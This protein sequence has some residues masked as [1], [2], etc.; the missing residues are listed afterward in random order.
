MKSHFLPLHIVFKDSDK[1]SLVEALLKNLSEKH[2]FDHVHL[3]HKEGTVG[4]CL[5]YS[6]DEVSKDEL[7]EIVLASGANIAD[8]YKNKS[9]I[10]K[11][12]HSA[13]CAR[14]IETTLR[15]VDGIY[16]VSVTYSGSRLIV[17]Y[18]AL[19]T[20]YADIK[21]IVSDLGYEISSINHSLTFLQK[22]REL[23]FS[24][25]SGITLLWAWYL[26]VNFYGQ[27]WYIAIWLSYFFG[28]FYTFKHSVHALRYMRLDIDILMLL[29]AFG[30]AF[31]GKWFEG[32][33]LLFLFS[34]GH[35]LEHKAMHKARSAVTGLAKLAPK[36][37]YVKFGSTYNATPVEDVNI[38]DIIQVK[39]GQSIACD[40]IVFSGTSSVNEAPITGESLPQDKAKG[41][42]V[43]AG[44]FNT[45]GVLLIKVTKVASESTV[46][47]MVRMILD[48]DAKKSSTQSFT[49]KFSSLFVPFV[50]FVVLLM[51]IV[52]PWAW[53]VDFYSS[54]YKAMLVLVAASPCALAIGTPA[55]VLSAV[56]RSAKLGVL[57]K[58]GKQL[59]RF[60][61]VSTLAMDKTGTITTGELV[62][63]KIEVLD[64]W[65]EEKILTYAASIEQYS[66]HPIA[67]A[68]VHKAVETNI[69]LQTA[70]DINELAGR[71]VVGFIGSHEVI[72]GNLK[73]FSKISPQ[74]RSIYKSLQKKGASTMLIAVDGVFKGAIAVSDHQRKRVSEI[75]I[76]L[77]NLGINKLVMLTGDNNNAAKHIANKVGLNEFYA[78]LLPEDKVDTISK[79]ECE[80]AG[81]VAMIGD[82]VNDAPAMTR[83]LLGIAMGG[84]GSDVALEAADI[85]LMN[86]DLSKLPQAYALSKKAELVIKQNVV[87]AL[88][89]IFVL[90]TLALLDQM[91]LSAT[92]FFHEIVS[93]LV[94]LN[95]LRL[96][97]FKYSR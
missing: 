84:A 1:E 20:N 56:A 83:A 5:H 48:A 65:S 30:A 7:A 23:F 88:L 80:S 91:S 3:M 36:V 60:A 43:F 39:P 34:L 59:E 70:K 14:L 54:F 69:S 85:V 87:L 11:Q 24:F 81:H 16:N 75:L 49:E 41:D 29:A 50:F 95:G 53:Q 92:V 79:L 19:K 2:H 90:V 44:T 35:G 47:K 97:N 40:G 31:I 46:S 42:K 18:D 74:V 71:G 27:L 52:P 86:D 62:L 17:E 37:A 73:T 64:D 9:F 51:I 78:E 26:H 63:S 22:N 82:G 66:N 6:E 76:E 61:M 28:A 72:I 8:N 4:L 67:R 45:H 12:M 96:L 25:F 68:L 93:V 55:A 13:D 33:L 15:R 58:G 57:I 77:K 94:V 89:S 21:S 38:G 32:G 10:I